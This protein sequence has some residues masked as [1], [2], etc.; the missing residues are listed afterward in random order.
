MVPGHML[1]AEPNDL[2]KGKSV[3]VS[4][5]SKNELILSTFSKAHGGTEHLWWTIQH[6]TG[7][8]P[9]ARIV[10]SAPMAVTDAHATL[11]P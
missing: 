1:T 7:L 4:P 6:L 8:G 3:P 2:C 5:F 9:L 11:S 10:I